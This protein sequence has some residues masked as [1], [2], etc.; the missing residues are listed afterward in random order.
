MKLDT[1]YPPR[2]AEP[3]ARVCA[4]APAP[5][6]SPRSR[7]LILALALVAVAGFLLGL[8]LPAHP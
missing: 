7:R 5:R 2:I 3:V 6:R 1:P 4:S 8:G